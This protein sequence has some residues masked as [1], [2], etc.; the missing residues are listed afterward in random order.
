MPAKFHEDRLNDG[1]TIY[2][3]VVKARAAMELGPVFANRCAVTRPS[4]DAP[5]L[6]SSTSCSV[7]MLSRAVCIWTAKKQKQKYISGIAAMSAG[8]I[9]V[10]T[11]INFVKTYDR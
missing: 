7:P 5:Y 11:I 1:L 3:I 2:F 9:L 4:C 8:Q 6:L 10:I